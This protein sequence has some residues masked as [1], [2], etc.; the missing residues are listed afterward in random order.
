MAQGRPRLLTVGPLITGHPSPSA[1]GSAHPNHMSALV[2]KHAGP[3]I[4]IFAD[5]TAPGAHTPFLAFRSLHLFFPP[6]GATSLCSWM[7]WLLPIF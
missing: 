1:L 6:P 5:P 3:G 2:V 7:G 4:R